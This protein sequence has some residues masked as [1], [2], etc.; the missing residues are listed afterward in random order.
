MTTLLVHSRAMTARHLRALWRQPWWIAVT[1]VQPVIWLLLFGALFE[2]VIEIPGFGATDYID[3]LTPGVVVMTALFSAGWLG[4]T[5]IQD[6]DL[7]IMDRFLVSPVRRS[8]LITGRLGYQAITTLIQS[9][10]V[11][12]LGLAVGGRFAGGAAGV[13]VL[14]G[15]AVL[16]GAAFGSLSN[17]L[18]LVVRHEETL[19]A[20]VQ[21]VVLPLAFLS[22]TF[23][24]ADLAPGWIQE[25]ARF[26]PVNWAVEAGREALG[27]GVD[28]SFVLPR[29][30]YLLAFALVCAW[31]STRA[32]RAYQRSV[33][34][35]SV[36]AGRSPGSHLG[37]AFIVGYM[38]L[39]SPTTCPSGSA[40]R[41]IVTW[42]SS[43]TG[44][45]VLPPSRSALSSI[46][47][48]S[49]VET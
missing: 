28:W 45:T 49:S 15:C 26:N 43:V 44:M 11:V 2:R 39:A 23:L 35:G 25:I 34:P 18:A 20:A 40:S 27:A 30:G 46:A 4:M 21:S 19:I 33:R 36:G 10:I 8:A 37:E 6:L 13:A 42:G 24:P 38:P 31:L 29:A 22:A 41:A 17:G 7:G 12:G 48:G 1:L 3:F 9:L 32:F 14:I 5:I 16:L 47:C